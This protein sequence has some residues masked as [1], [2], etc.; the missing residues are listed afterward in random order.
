MRYAI[1]SVP[2]APVR[3]EDSHRSEMTNQL[4]FGET[5]EILEE[6]G[7]WFRIRSQYDGYEGW[8]TWHLVD[9]L[10]A[11]VMAANY[12]AGGIINRV[13]SAAGELHIPFGAPLPGLDPQS[14]VF[15]NGR[16][17]LQQAPHL[18]ETTRDFLQIEHVA[19]RWLQVPYLWG[20][21]TLMGVDCSGF[22][23]NIFRYCGIA[24]KRDAW[25]QAEEG[26]SVAGLHAAQKGDLAFFNNEAGRIV[27]VGILLHQ[28]RIIHA[29]GKVRIDPISNEGIT[30]SETG[31]KTHSLHSI[32]RY[33]NP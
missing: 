18:P 15:Y 23:Q 12:I 2:A 31:K 25:Q 33:Y 30:H 16:Y 9:D 1:C 20:G 24:L 21:K 32:R 27:H 10:L 6:K 29:A 8:L 5:M 22:V 13:S 14:G 26:V 3:K 19:S 4:L 17:V 28:N 7:E 11:D